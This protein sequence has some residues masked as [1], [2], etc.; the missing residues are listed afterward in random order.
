MNL[1]KILNLYRSEVCGLDIG[2]SAVKIVAMHKE[3]TGYKVIAAGM[4]QIADRH[5]QVE[6]MRT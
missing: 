2:S 3:N 6:S 5:K 1:K 4:L